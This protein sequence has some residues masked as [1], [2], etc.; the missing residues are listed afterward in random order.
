MSL[1][2][3]RR[4]VFSVAVMLFASSI[5]TTTIAA[6]P[7]KEST[8]GV[9]SGLDAIMRR[10]ISAE[11]PGCAVGVRHRGVDVQR[12][13]GQA[14]LE[15]NVAN[16][17]DSVFNIGSIGKQFT[18]AAVLLLV[19]DGRLKLDDDVRKYLPELGAQPPI[20]IDALLSHTSGLR[21]FRFTD[22]ILGRDALAQGNADVLAYASRQ[23]GLNHAPGESHLYTNTGYVL[24][25]IVV[26]RVSGRSFSD[27]TRER[28]FGPAGMNR[29]QWEDDA[30]R[31][32]LGRSVGYS[33]AEAGRDGEPSSF[34]QMPTARHTTGHGGA[35]STVGDMLRWNE[36]LSRDVFGPE[37][38]VRLQQRARLRNGFVLDY[39]RGVYVGRHR[40]FEEVQHSGY[41]G[42]Y[43]AWVGRY[44]E[45]DLSIALLCNGDADEVAP[46]EIAD[47]FLPHDRQESVAPPSGPAP[48]QEDLS[49]RSG[50]YRN[51][52]T[53][54]PALLN[55]PQEAHVTEGRYTQGPN[56][57]EFDAGRPMRISQRAYGD[58]STWDAMES[59]T[60]S[61]KALREFEGRFD[62][63]EL[64]AGFEVRSDG[65]QLTL[66]VRGLSELAMVARPRAR[67]VFEMQGMLVEFVRAENGRIASL[68]LSPT[69]LR[70]LS[71]RKMEE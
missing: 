14:D 69:G 16:T 34:V 66:A 23:R 32:V 5:P 68:S 15:R 53:G 61:A 58:V 9:V 29:T 46:R 28:L 67:D 44:P 24:L 7:A 6:E 12:A 13:Y 54:Q 43:T 19:Q 41:T 26:E 64:L 60:P 4:Y 37:L 22:W 35:L 56:T 21:D 17:V 70:A 59:W 65:Q 57:Y 50:V 71:F 40:G 45:A 52:R 33:L 49:A 18:A 30:R 63:D 48:H 20:T 27:F 62:S 55:F 10:N 31:V 8:S 2:S 42:T 39:A 47:L 11:T 3:R 36:A 51:I 25:A 38:R 1:S